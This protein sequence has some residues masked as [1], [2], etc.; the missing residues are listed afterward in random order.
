MPTD[1]KLERG[2]KG[3]QI[4]PKKCPNCGAEFIFKLHRGRVH[5]VGGDA[6][7]HPQENVV[8]CSVCMS[9]FKYEPFEPRRVPHAASS[10]TK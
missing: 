9:T 10:K 7:Y 3:Y 5:D 1:I 6:L 2:V 4:I 8:R